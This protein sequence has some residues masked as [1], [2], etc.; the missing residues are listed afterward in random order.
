MSLR[1]GSPVTRGRAIALAFTLATSGAYA[2]DMA[3][4]TLAGGVADLERCL[5]DTPDNPHSCAGRLAN[6]CQEAP[7]GGTTIGI[8]A[9]LSQES[10]LWDQLLN[11]RYEATMRATRE[12]ADEIGR[13]GP[14]AVAS[15]RDAQRKWIGYRD[16]ECGRL[17]DRWSGSTI[18]SIVH[19]SC[20]L[21]QTAARAIDLA[22]DAER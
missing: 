2:Q 3:S 21:E 6:R 20:V 7:D 18:R 13:D 14:D 10:D 19:A 8:V 15:L 5:A 9:C 11:T 17:H 1:G 12:E 4:S 16:A 22:P